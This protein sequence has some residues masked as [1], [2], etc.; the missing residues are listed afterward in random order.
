M[1]EFIVGLLLIIFAGWLAL[2]AAGWEL[3][4]NFT[5]QLL[6]WISTN[7][8]KSILLSL[9][10]FLLGLFLIKRPRPETEQLFVSR[11]DAGELRITRG[12][13]ADIIYRSTADIAK[14]K[15]LRSK[16]RQTE[17]GLHITVICQLEEGVKIAP[18]SA[19]IQERVKQ[20][21]ELYSG[22][23]VKEVRVLV[24]SLNPIRAAYKK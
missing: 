14:I 21:V 19:K 3:P 11:N 16:I 23:P 4:Y 10:I 24:R 18:I 7:S 6:D 1:F 15:N 17:N 9:I 5:L 2:L 13:M 20:D 8:L 12:A 22:I